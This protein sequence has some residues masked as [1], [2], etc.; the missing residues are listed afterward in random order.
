M[1][2]GGQNL[3][4]ADAETFETCNPRLGIT[5]TVAGFGFAIQPFNYPII[6]GNTFPPLNDDLTNMLGLTPTTFTQNYY[7]YVE[8]GYASMLYTPYFDVISNLL[9]KNQNVQDSSSGK[10]TTTAKLARVY[11]SNESIAQRTVT[12]TFPGGDA[13]F[14]SS[15]DNAIG[16]CGFYSFRREFITPKYIQWNTTENVDVVDLQLVDYRGNLL[17]IEQTAVQGE[18]VPPGETWLLLSNTADF[19]FTLQVS[20]V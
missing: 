15:S 10:F 7:T 9:T 13:V 18:A 20:E 17:P 19:Q 16:C 2:I 12:M 14:T 1:Q 6:N 3:T 5:C 8:G 4:N 11:L